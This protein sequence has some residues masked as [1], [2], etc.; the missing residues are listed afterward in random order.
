MRAGTWISRTFNWTLPIP[1]SPT[2]ASR[3]RSGARRNWTEPMPSAPTFRHRQGHPGGG[4]HLQVSGSVEKIFQAPTTRDLGIAPDLIA[5]LAARTRN[6]TSSVPGIESSN[7]PSCPRAVT[8]RPWASRPTR[9]NPPQSSQ[10]PAQTRIARIPDNPGSWRS[11][12]RNFRLKRGNAERRYGV[13]PI[14]AFCK[15]LK[16]TKSARPAATAAAA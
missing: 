9:P 6:I 8:T 3:I 14:P 4:T 12:Y 2:N 15:T 10:T 16:A 1:F 5:H 11:A 13:Y 7:C